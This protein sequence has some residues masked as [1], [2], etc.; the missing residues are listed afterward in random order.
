[1]PIIQK[2][3]EDSK[4]DDEGKEPE[5]KIVTEEEYR[6]QMEAEI[7]EDVL[8]QLGSKSKKKKKKIVSEG[9]TRHQ[10]SLRLAPDVFKRL[11]EAAEFESRSITNLV[12]TYLEL[13]YTI[14]TWE[15][16]QILDDYNGGRSKARRKR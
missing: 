10:F 12:I 5:P 9:G 6:A 4:P 2:S 11:Q 14:P 3:P 1:M 16:R 13:V 15:L 7:R 8:A